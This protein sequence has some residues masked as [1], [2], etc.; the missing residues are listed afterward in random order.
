[1]L[2]N[3]ANSLIIMNIGKY[4]QETPRRRAGEVGRLACFDTVNETEFLLALFF[5][6]VL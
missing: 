2:R 3:E 5:Y 4:L 1:M 6:I